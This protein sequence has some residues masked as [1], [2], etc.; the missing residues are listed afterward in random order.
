MILPTI[1]RLAERCELLNEVRGTQALAL[2]TPGSDRAVAPVAYVHPIAQRGGPNRL[3]NATAQR[4]ELRVGV[5]LSIAVVA[6]TRGEEAVDPIEQLTAEVRAALVG[7]RPGGAMAPYTFESGT[8]QRVGD[9]SL[10][11]L[12]T[13]VTDIELRAV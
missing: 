11:W 5:L 1:D 6:Q 8:M 3:I 9:G 7:W 10:W 4:V 13:F 12:E 2:L